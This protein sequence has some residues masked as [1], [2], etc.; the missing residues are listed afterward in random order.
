MSLYFLFSFL[1]VKPS[2][3]ESDGCVDKHE[4]CSFWA[5]LDECAKN[6]NYMLSNCPVSCNTCENNGGI[7]SCSDTHE[8]CSFWASIDECEKNPRYML[9]NCPESCNSC[10]FDEDTFGEI[11][12][13]EICA[14]GDHFCEAAKVQTTIPRFANADGSARVAS[15]DCND[16]YMECADYATDGECSNNPGWMIVN[17]PLSCKLC[18]LRDPKV[19]CSR[20]KLNMSTSPVYQPGDMNS[21]FQSLVEDYHDKHHVEILS[22]DPWVVTFEN[23]LSDKEASALI[24]KQDNWERSTDTGSS[25]EYGETG[26]ILSSGRTSSNS[27]CREECE[28]DPHVQ[29]VIQRIEG[30]T[31][32]GR[33]NFE[34]F[35]VLKCKV[36]VFCSL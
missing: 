20:D 24:A 27:W 26:R 19:R 34:S 12:V 21:M 14:D 18:E 13:E 8:S 3:S 2:V 15:N 33:E 9:K 5:G 10:S 6:P 22:T 36:F 35:Q 31:R 25:N 1:L 4:S 28:A 32:I 7:A 23:F 29:N 30:V 11:Q 17:C 16:R